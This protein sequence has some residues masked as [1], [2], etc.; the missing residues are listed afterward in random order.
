MRMLPR[1]SSVGMALAICALTVFAMPP[2]AK[3]GNA[4]AGSEVSTVARNERSTPR[5]SI[6]PFSPAIAPRGPDQ[7][8]PPPVAVAKAILVRLGYDVGRLDDRTTA[9]FKAAVFEFQRARGLASSGNFDSA[10][11]EALGLLRR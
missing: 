5:N 6:L 10:T 2:V 4:L 1:I 8:P 11:L 7:V 9:K 3:S